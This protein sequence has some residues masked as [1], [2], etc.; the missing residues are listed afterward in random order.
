MMTLLMTTAN[1]WKK[2]LDFFLENLQLNQLKMQLLIFAGIMVVIKMDFFFKLLY[3][4]QLLYLNYSNYLNYFT[5]ITLIA[6]VFLT[7][8]L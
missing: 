7:K 3:F 1:P 2:T 8:L 4:L 5:L 6:F